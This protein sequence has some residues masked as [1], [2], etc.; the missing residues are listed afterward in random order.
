[1]TGAN[2]EHVVRD[3]RAAFDDYEAAPGRN[4]VPALADFFC[5]DTRT[6]RIGPEGRR[7]A[8]AHVSLQP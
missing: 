2:L 1:M 5:N 6:V 4:D 3:V 7:I 8:S